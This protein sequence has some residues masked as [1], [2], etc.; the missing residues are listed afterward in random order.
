MWGKWCS[1]PS[2]VKLEKVIGLLLGSPC[3]VYA[4]LEHRH[5]VVRNPRPHGEVTYEYSAPQPSIHYQT[6]NWKWMIQ[7]SVSSSLS[8][9]WIEQ[10]WTIPVHPC[11]NLSKR[12]N[13]IDLRNSISELFAILGYTEIWHCYDGKNPSDK[14]F[15]V[16]RTWHL[17]TFKKLRSNLQTKMQRPRISRNM[18]SFDNFIYLY[19]HP[20][21]RNKIFSLPKVSSHPRSSV[22]ESARNAAWEA[23]VYVNSHSSFSHVMLEARNLEIESVYSMKIS[24]CY[25]SRLASHP[26]RAHC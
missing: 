7:C 13:A 18:R 15:S 26:T 1:V 25:K 17:T 11:P 21:R 24:K 14:Y 19:P 2:Q 9:H 6:S 3:L 10:K 8:S 22:L 12:N 20:R 16:P 4:P 23:I 5:Y